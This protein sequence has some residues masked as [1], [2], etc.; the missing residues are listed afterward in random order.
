[1]SSACLGDLLCGETCSG[2]TYDRCAGYTGKTCPGTG[3]CPRSSFCICTSSA[4]QTSPC[5]S[6]TTEAACAGSTGCSWETTCGTGP[7]SCYK[8][9]DMD[10]CRAQPSCHVQRNCN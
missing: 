7:V 2:G 4:C 8:I 3:V 9:S 6:L 10:E 1:M 5:G